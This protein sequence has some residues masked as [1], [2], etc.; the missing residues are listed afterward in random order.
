MTAKHYL[1]QIEWLDK[2]INRK[3]AEIDQLYAIAT[4]ITVA[5]KDV[6]VQ[7]SSEQ[8]KLGNIVTK[9]TEANNEAN[10]LIDQFWDLKCAAWRLISKLDREDYREI[11]HQ[12][13]FLYKSIYQIAKEQGKDYE[14]M[15]KMHGRAL[16]ECDKILHVVCD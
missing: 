2:R 9:I 15:K 10:A 5:L 8:D 7:A 16:L 12:R 4:S 13:Y 11:L 3:L 14:N 1:L 6:N